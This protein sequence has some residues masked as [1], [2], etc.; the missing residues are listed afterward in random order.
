MKIE[1]SANAVA[2]LQNISEF[3]ERDRNLDTA[4]RISR[5]F[6]EAAQSL[7]RLPYRGRLGRVEGTR[8]LLVLPLPYVVVY[9]I[10]AE[11]ILIVNIVHGAQ[12][13]P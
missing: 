5:A 13:W 11:R 1:W 8:E 6:F 2:D 7:L 10:A 9:R 4:N 12:R 3:I